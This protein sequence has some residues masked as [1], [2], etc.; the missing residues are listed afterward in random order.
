[1]TTDKAI[2]DIA[3]EQKAIRK[4]LEDINKCIRAM[5]ECMILLA[6]QNGPEYRGP[7]GMTQSPLFMSGKDDQNDK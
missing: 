2:Q 4:N 7:E 1:M 6:R 5:T 3:N